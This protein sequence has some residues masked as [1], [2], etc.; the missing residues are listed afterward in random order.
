M[1]TYQFMTAQGREL[2]QHLYDCGCYHE[3]EYSTDGLIHLIRM[4]ICGDCFDRAAEHLEALDKQRQLTLS[5]DSPEGD[6]R[7]EFN[8]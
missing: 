4:E 8:D 2:V 1:R 7:Q 6:R 3:T 5:L